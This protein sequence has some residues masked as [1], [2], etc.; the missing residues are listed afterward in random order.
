MVLIP[1]EEPT[2]HG[3]PQVL[4][5][6]RYEAYLYNNVHNLIYVP[7]LGNILPAKV[8]GECPFCQG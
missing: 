6:V 5:V 8:I 4:T 3:P 1:R 2:G 7:P